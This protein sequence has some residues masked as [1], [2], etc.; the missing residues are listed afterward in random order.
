MNF[1]ASMKAVKLETIFT[2][3]ELFSLVDILDLKNVILDL[4]PFTLC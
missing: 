2:N 3:L 1:E 4:A